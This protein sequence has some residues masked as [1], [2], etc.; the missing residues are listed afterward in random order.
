MKIRNFITELH[1]KT[2]RNY[3]ERMNN[4]KVK[5]MKVAKKI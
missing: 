3:L 1:L 2:K 4:N 5:C